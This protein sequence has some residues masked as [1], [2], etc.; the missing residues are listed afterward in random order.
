MAN[1][2]NLGDKQISVL[3]SLYERNGWS[4]GCGWIWDTVSGT[5]RI[6]DALVKRE[7]ATKT[8]ENGRRAKYRINDAGIQAL[9]DNFPLFKLKYDEKMKK[10]V[11]DK[12]LFRPH[13]GT[14]EASVTL[15]KEV[16]A[17]SDLVELAKKQ[18]PFYKGEISEATISI[19]SRGHDDRIGWDTQRVTLEGYGVIGYTSKPFRAVS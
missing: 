8:E 19:E 10:A 17:L 6:L 18:H 12:V 13:R 1:T 3:R 7:L 9:C 5:V 11:S 14:L 4:S 16:A 15:V 2:K